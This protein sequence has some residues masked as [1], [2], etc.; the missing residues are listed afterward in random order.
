MWAVV[1]LR[2][3]PPPAWAYAYVAAASAQLEAFSPLD[4]GMMV[5]ALQEYNGEHGLDKVRARWR[6][7]ASC[8]MCLFVSVVEWTASLIV[9]I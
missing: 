3:N 4:L 2:L 5:R 1:R 7:G 6:L 9:I 8:W